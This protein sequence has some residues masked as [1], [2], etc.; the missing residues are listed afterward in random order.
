MT[1]R[2]C[3]NLRS[4]IDECDLRLLGLLGDYRL[5]E[6]VPARAVDDSAPLSLG[7]LRR[8]GIVGLY[9]TAEALSR[10]DVVRHTGWPDPDLVLGR[11]I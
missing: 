9:V 7:E 5:G 4:P 11:E 3:T 2:H 1:Y 10:P 6:P 8:Q